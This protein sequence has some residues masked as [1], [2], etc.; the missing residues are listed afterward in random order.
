MISTE[1][2]IQCKAAKC[3]YEETLKIKQNQVN[4]DMHTNKEELSIAEE[5]DDDEVIEDTPPRLIEKNSRVRT[6]TMTVIL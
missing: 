4:I 1:N 2:S 6:L 3:D 5:L